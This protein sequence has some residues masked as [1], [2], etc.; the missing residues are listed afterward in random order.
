MML[1]ENPFQDL[2]G[3]H[4]KVQQTDLSLGHHIIAMVGQTTDL[5]DL[6]QM[7]SHCHV[8]TGHHIIAM[9]GLDKAATGRRIDLIDQDQAE[10][11]AVATVAEAVHKAKAADMVKAVHKVAVATGHSFA[12]ATSLHSAVVVFRA[13]AVAV[14]AVAVR[15]AEPLVHL[16]EVAN[17]ATKSSKRQTNTVVVKN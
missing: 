16:A 5:Q 13:V 1:M 14:Q 8:A 11:Q 12:V 9:A 17:L 10:H 7:A 2:I 15:A 3:R 4:A 6:A